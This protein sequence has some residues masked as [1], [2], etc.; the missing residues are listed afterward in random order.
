MKVCGLC[1]ARYSDTERF[2][3]NDGNALSDES[4]QSR[5]T[6]SKGSVPQ[7]AEV[8]NKPWMY[9]V[10][11]AAAALVGGAAILFIVMTLGSDDSVES[12]RSDRVENSYLKSPTP[13]SAASPVRVGGPPKPE[14]QSAGATGYEEDVV[15]ATIA[16]TIQ[17]WKE[18]GEARSVDRYMEFY[19]G[20]IEPYYR[21]A[22]ASEAFVR[23][24]KAKAFA[25]YP[26]VSVSVSAIN[27]TPSAD[28]QSA[29]A[30]FDK[31][32]IFN[33]NCST[34]GKVRQELKFRQQGGQWRI[35]GERDDKIYYTRR[36]G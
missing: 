4:I 7:A 15:H 17:R 23:E 5:K 28:L 34:A 18:A 33:N 36:C 32:W 25:K 2:C 27:V 22:A 20:S 11:G 19:G 6:F 26:I 29:T 1:N 31:A 16:E 21:K 30:V 8:R 10:I 3:L 14:P 24:D 9:V 13:Q 12:G 35:V